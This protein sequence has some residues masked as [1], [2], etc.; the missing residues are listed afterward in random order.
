MFYLKYFDVQKYSYYHQLKRVYKHENQ[1]ILS[2]FLTDDKSFLTNLTCHFL[3]II[4]CLSSFC[5]HCWYAD[6]SC[7]SRLAKQNCTNFSVT[8]FLLQFSRKLKSSSDL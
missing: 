2:S 3:L 1:P 4:S 5:W 8:L 6:E 7:R